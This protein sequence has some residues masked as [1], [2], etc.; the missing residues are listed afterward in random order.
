MDFPKDD[1]VYR[2]FSPSSSN[3]LSTLHMDIASY[4]MGILAI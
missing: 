4:G 3:S 1:Q 2:V